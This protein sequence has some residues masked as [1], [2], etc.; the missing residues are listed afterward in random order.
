MPIN[1]PYLD[2]EYDEYIEEVLTRQ[3]KA[4]FDKVNRYVIPFQKAFDNPNSDRH[5]KIDSFVVH[6]YLQLLKQLYE[7]A[8][9]ELTPIKELE[10]VIKTLENLMESINFDE[11]H[12]NLEL[13]K[14]AQLT[15]LSPYQVSVNIYTNLFV[16]IFN[17]QV[18]CYLED[19]NIGLDDVL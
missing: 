7:N 9:M 3:S 8:D 6:Y 18:R 13:E 14:N 11:L 17:A 5:T 1:N 16:D 15:S 19:N 2:N 4:I 12:I 10:V